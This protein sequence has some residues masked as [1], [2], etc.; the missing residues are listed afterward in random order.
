MFITSLKHEIY[1]DVEGEGFA[2]R[3]SCTLEIEHAAEIFC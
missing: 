2:M 1:Q 3:I